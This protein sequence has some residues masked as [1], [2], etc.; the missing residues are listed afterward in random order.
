MG[1]LGSGAIKVEGAILILLYVWVGAY[2]GRG[3][4]SA[5]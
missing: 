1:E 4:L 2:M 5:F 3:P